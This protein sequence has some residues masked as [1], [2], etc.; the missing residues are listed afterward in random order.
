M[1]KEEE[2]LLRLMGKRIR[3]LRINAGFTSQESFAY[4]AGIPRAQYGRYEAGT[5]ITI[6]SLNKIIKFHKLSLEEFFKQGF[7][8]SK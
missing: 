1:T 4:E 6:L 5:N 2:K 3:D 7:D 8:K